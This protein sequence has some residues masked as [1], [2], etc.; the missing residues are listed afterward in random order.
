MI[1]YMRLHKEPFESIKSGNKTYELRLYD[2]KRQKIRAGDLI[3]FT[4]SHDEQ[5]FVRVKS[6]HIFASFQEL[7]IRCRF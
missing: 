1:H 5:L 6:L 4:S 7:M 3:C 2:E